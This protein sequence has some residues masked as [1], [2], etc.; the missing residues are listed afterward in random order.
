MIHFS[1]IILTLG[2]ALRVPATLHCRDLELVV[3]N[4][5]VCHNVD[6]SDLI[7]ALERNTI[8][9]TRGNHLFRLRHPFKDATEVFAVAALW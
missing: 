4:E 9:Q 1:M 5:F 2:Q 3:A 6:R 7:M 8:Y